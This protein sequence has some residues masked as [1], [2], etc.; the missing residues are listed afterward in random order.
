M[1]QKL[2]I[3][4]QSNLFK[5]KKPYQYIGSEHLSYNKEWALS[6]VKIALAFPDKYEIAISN[7]GQKI[8]YNIINSNDELLADR[9]Y[10]PDFDYME[11]IKSQNIS[12]K[13][14]ETKKDL[15]EFDFIGFSLQ[16]ELSYPTVLSMLNLSKVPV[17]RNERNEDHP[18]ILAGGPCCYNPKPMSEF[19]DIFLIGDGEDLL[20]ELLLKY[21]ELKNKKLTRNEIIK[22]FSN[23]EGVYS[24]EFSKKTKKRISQLELK[25]CPITSPLPYSSSVHDRVVVEIRR[26]CGRMCRFCQPGHV[27]LPIRERKAEDIINLVLKSVEETG[28][29]EY[30]LLSLSSN[31]YGNIESVIEELSCHLNDKKISSSLP[32]QR[33]DRY[34]E[35]LASLIR[36]VRKSTVTLAPEA[37]SQRLRNVI[38]KNLTEEQIIETILT[39]YKNGSDSVKLYFILGLPTETYED[40]DEL[41]ELF[42]KIKYQ[43]KL[44]RTEENLK[45]AL[46]ITCTLSIFVP[47]PFTPFQW[48]GQNSGEEIKQKIDYLMPK[49]KTIK[50]VKINYH[51]SFVSKLESVL[52]RGDESLNE[53]IYKLYEKGVYMST[54]DENIDKNLWEDTAKEAGISLTELATKQFDLEEELPWD[55]IDIGIDKSWFIQEYKKALLSETTIPCEFNCVS[56][57]VC[58]NLNQ[59]KVMDKTYSP[60]LFKSEKQEQ[61]EVYKYRIKLTKEDELRYLSHLDWQNTIIKSLFRSGLNLAFSQGFNPTPKLSLGIALPIFYESKCELIDLELKDNLTTEE[62]KE[63]LTKV[64]PEKVEILDVVKI[65]KEAKSIDTTAQ[66]ALY[67]CAPVEEGILK[68]QDLMY[69]ID[70]ISS[71]DEIFIE[72]KTKKGIKKLVNIK[73]SIKSAYV[74]NDMLMLILK[75]GQNV[76]L[77][78]LKADELIRL[79]YPDV[80]FRIVRTKFF[81]ENHNEL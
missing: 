36:G 48:Y 59:K 69:I 30:S 75:T 33:I 74:E 44:L 58:K 2:D 60:K 62:L 40:I 68:I 43:S 49:A 37:G 27:N 8:L 29:D 16:Y 51:N 9:A 57:G 5:V 64:V 14:L 72:K 18:I 3:K 7:L 34:S 79:F 13:G 55:V 22:E 52:S 12:L 19:I 76:D 24:P 4:S 53:F 6:S 54:W 61:Q 35:K 67:E 17:R 1:P 15:S 20:I 28:Y 80:D 73:P 66:W 56:C 45:E 38:N 65:P 32:S 47:K 46:K 31:D 41:V 26:G 77:P 11:I 39:C 25:T 63:S 70:K 42:K 21:K 81:D 23:I 71:S 10:A 78:S 50:G